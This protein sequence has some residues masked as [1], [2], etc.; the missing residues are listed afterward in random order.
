MS[1]PLLAIAQLNSADPTF[2]QELQSLL[3]APRDDAAVTQAVT[4]MRQNIAQNGDAAVLAYSEQHDHFHPA[5]CADLELPPAIW[6]NAAAQLPPQLAAD[7]RGAA[8]RLQRYHRH[9]RPTPWTY[10]DEHGNTLGEAI[11][12]VDRAVIYAPGGTAAYPS[13]VLMGVIPAVIAGV[14]EIILTTPPGADGAPP[15]PVTLAAAAMAGCHRV[16]M[17]G[18][19]HAVIAFALGTDTLPAADVVTGPGNAYVAEAKRQLTGTV[20]IDSMAGPSEVLIIA[21]DSAPSEWIAADLAAQAEHDPMAQSILITPNPDLAQAVTAALSRLVPTLP[22]AQII[23]T[24]LESRGAVIIAQDMT[25]AVQL[26]NDIAPEHL[27]IMTRDADTLATQIT[28]AGAIFIGVHACVPFGDY[29]AGTNHILP[30]SGTARFSSPLGVHHYIK[31]SGIF[32]ATQTGAA[33]LAAQTARLAGAEGLTA[34]AHAA[35]LRQAP[36]PQIT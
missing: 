26:A 27:Q 30:T 11:T 28:H 35:T 12:P 9:Q 22:R 21:D 18:G 4:A 33:A 29:L 20:G 19:A 14:P 17:L 24:A 31:R 32:R 8:D 13:S 34:H 2:P 10:Q 3:A 6:Q 23:R 5:T 1:T 36:P 7:L 16:F 25:D 15:P